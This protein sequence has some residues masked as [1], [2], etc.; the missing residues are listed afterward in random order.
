M[1]MRLLFS[2]VAASVD[3]ADFHMVFY[4]S[5]ACTGFLHG[6]ATILVTSSTYGAGMTGTVLLSLLVVLS[7]C[8]V[9][10]VSLQ[11]CLLGL[12]L[13]LLEAVNA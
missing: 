9:S 1:E 5:C 12:W 2:F 3:K 8:W 10:V 13:T 11:S 6:S 4:A 7:K